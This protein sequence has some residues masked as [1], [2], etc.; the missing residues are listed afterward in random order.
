M[1]FLTPNRGFLATRDGELRRTSDGGRT[2][3]VVSAGR[4]FV[5]LSFVSSAAGFALTTG[6]RFASTRDGGRSWR[7]VHA[8]RS[9][10]ATGPYSGAIEFVDAT[11]GWAAPSGWGSVYRTVDGGATW[12][13]QPFRCGLALGGFSFVDD[14]NGFLICGGQPATIDQQKNLYISA[15]GGE[16]WRRRACVHAIGPRCPGNLALA[17]YASGVAFRDLR[18]GL[19]LADRSGIARTLDGGRHWKQ[20]LFTDDAYSILSVS[21]AS[22]R[23]VYGLSLQDGTLI[24]SDDAGLRWRRVWPVGS[25]APTGAV[26]FS[27]PTRGIGITAGR[28]LA[29]AG[30]VAT[31]DGGKTWRH[32]ASDHLL[33]S[34]LVRSGA[35]VVWAVGFRDLPSGESR[36]FLVRS[37]DDGRHWRRMPTPTAL[38]VPALS[39]PTPRIGFLSDYSKR[40]FRT[41][42]G[43]RS[44]H[45]V[46][47]ARRS[48]RGAIFVS[49]REGLL[50][51]DHGLSRTDD[52]GRSWRHVRVTP[53]MR[54][55]GAAVL[56]ARHW[57]LAGYTCPNAGKTIGPKIPGLGFAKPAPCAG[58]SYLLRTA[59]GGRSWTA[60]R[61][62]KPPPSALTFVTPTVGYSAA[63]PDG[64]YRTTDAGRSWHFLHVHGPA[65]CSD[66][67]L[68]LSVRTQGTAT[69]TA[70]FLLASNRGR[71]PC[72]LTGTAGFEI[73]QRDHKARINGNPFS[74]HLETTLA[75]GRTVTPDVWWANWC[76][77]RRELSVVVR[78]RRRV[79]RAPF[80]VL[81]AC[82]S[83]GERSTLSRPS[84]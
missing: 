82:I 47:T 39:F 61:F 79:I 77:S 70:I 50:A 73:V 18:T 12:R 58:K 21:W 24:R 4:R 27:S 7:I 20:T 17:G 64:I 44:W 31:D 23:T 10:A 46:T 78:L 1:D 55:V 11:D 65:A 38:D 16:T 42:D 68:R 33:D 34:E 66:S 76:G 56:D 29:P 9:P 49:T 30:I 36:D 28:L 84:S 80:R 13:R 62:G 32:A 67:Q 3:Q 71:E 2:W 41:D 74:R 8:F 72:V 69:Q 19:L 63:G 51:G 35:H 26:S 5:S 14:S 75:P 25:G 83:R 22:T 54:F 37:S 52:G 45:L 48:L 43:G 60:I 59:D 6:G 81:P 57:W 40:L 53:Q 15:D